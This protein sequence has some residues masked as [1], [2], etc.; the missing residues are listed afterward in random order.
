VGSPTCAT[1]SGDEEKEEKLRLNT[2][3]VSDNIVVLIN[4]YIGDSAD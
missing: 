3:N 1:A 2:T 4:V